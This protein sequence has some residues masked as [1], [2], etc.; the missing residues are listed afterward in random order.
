MSGAYKC[1][2][3][4]VGACYEPCPSYD[5]GEE[6]RVCDMEVSLSHRWVHKVG[7]SDPKILSISCGE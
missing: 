2:R 7:P 1:G 4:K 5:V 3:V 6:V